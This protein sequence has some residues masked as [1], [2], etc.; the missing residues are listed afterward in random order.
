MRPPKNATTSE[1]VR[2]LR[3]A[4]RMGQAEFARQAGLA[5]EHLSNV[6]RGANK[7]GS[8]AMRAALA[9]GVGVGLE[10]MHAYLEG[11]L[12]LAGLLRARKADQAA[13]GAA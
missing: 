13:R 6:E 10:E 1:R 12:S 8:A 9:R 3:A 5:R 11:S 2:A 4:M 7:A